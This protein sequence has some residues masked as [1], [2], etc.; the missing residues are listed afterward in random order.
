MTRTRPDQ[1]GSWTASSA[2][3]R[4]A[5]TKNRRLAIPVAGFV[6]TGL[7]V[8]RDQFLRVNTVS[9][10]PANLV[11]ELLPEVVGAPSPRLAARKLPSAL[12]EMLNRDP[13]SPFHGLIRRASIGAW[14]AGHAGR[15]R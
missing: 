2:V 15:H 9:P 14:P 11:T 6:A 12:V 3:S 8:Q 7:D 1:R 4:L 5:R 10:L 13:E